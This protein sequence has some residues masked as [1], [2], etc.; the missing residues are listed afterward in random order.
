LGQ[1]RQVRLRI[2]FR[3][4]AANVPRLDVGRFRLSE[5]SGGLVENP[6]VVE[7]FGQV[8]QVC[9]GIGLRQPF[10]NAPYLFVGSFS[11]SKSIR[12]GVQGS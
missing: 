9:L 6:E 3:Q 8:R 11:I 1:V 4:L 7:G 5:P 12:I 2:G 10:E